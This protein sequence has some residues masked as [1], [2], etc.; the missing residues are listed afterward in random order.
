MGH[1]IADIINLVFHGFLAGAVTFYPIAKFEGRPLYCSHTLSDPTLTY[2]QETANRYGPWV[3]LDVGLYEAGRVKCGDKL[4]LWLENKQPFE[5][6]ALDA[7]TFAGYFV[8]E[9]PT[10]PVIADLPEYWLTESTRG[11]LSLPAH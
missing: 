3:A 11:L 5:V 8:A 2:S 10:L 7:G 9:W 6:T 4:L 1:T